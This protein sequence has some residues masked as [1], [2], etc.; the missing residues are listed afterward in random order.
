VDR[1]GDVTLVQVGEDLFEVFVG[2]GFIVMFTES[3]TGNRLPPPGEEMV[4]AERLLHVS[5]AEA[6]PRRHTPRWG[7]WVGSSQALL[8]LTRLIG[9]YGRFALREGGR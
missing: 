7:R 1:E 5:L 8:S 3:V 4:A 2:S 6:R 9:W